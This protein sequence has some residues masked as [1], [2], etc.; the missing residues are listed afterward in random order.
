MSDDEC[1]F[2]RLCSARKLGTEHGKMSTNLPVGVSYDVLSAS[3]H[4]PCT[5]MCF[6]RPRS[7]S[8][9]HELMFS[10]RQHYIT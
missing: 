4:A 3:D 9:L 8:S 7:V 10:L 6:K 2:V 5:P 1:N